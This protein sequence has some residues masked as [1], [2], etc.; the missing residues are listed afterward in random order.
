LL[1]IVRSK[2]PY[3][4]VRN[5]NLKSQP[6]VADFKEYHVLKA[7]LKG[8]P[9]I[10][11]EDAV[12]TTLQNTRQFLKNYKECFAVLLWRAQHQGAGRRRFTAPRKRQL[13]IPLSDVRDLGQLLKETRR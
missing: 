10:G 7:D 1:S 9:C 12:A 8:E 13:E 3:L 2:W 6:R 11:N 4:V 5:P